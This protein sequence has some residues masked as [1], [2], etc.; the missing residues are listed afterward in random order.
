M[1]KFNI[2]DATIVTPTNVSRGVITVQDGKI[3]A[4]IPEEDFNAHDNNIPQIDANGAYVLPG[5][6]DIHTDAI[7][8]EIM[9]RKGADFPIEIAFRELERRMSGCG[10]TT[11]YHSMH[12]G[13]KKAE[14]SAQ[15][16]YSRKEI[17]DRIH[18]CCNEKSV[19]NNKIHLRFELTGTYHYD[20]VMELIESG[21]ID[22]L[23]VMDH[24]PGQG[25]YGKISIEEW[26]KRVEISTDEAAKQLEELKNQDC[27]DGE[28]LTSMINLAVKKGIAVASHDDDSAE[29]VEQMH[30]IGINISEFPINDEAAQRALEL[31]MHTVAG[32][33]NVIR[34][35]SLSGNLNVKEAIQKNLIQS[36][37]SDYYPPSILHALFM[38]VNDQVLSLPQAANLTALNPAKSVN[39]SDE[40]GSIEVGKN[41]D[42]IVVN[43]ENKLPVVSHTFV[44]GNLA[45]MASLKNHVN[46]KEPCL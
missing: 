44:N 27:I 1:D 43:L 18:A 34:G 45:A 39:I 17:F 22:L 4:I 26:A 40:T 3:A 10:I 32:A 9:P 37:C 25:Q 24:R 2:I 11:V 23:S 20:L 7:D 19:I 8:K 38:L 42:L 13:Y 41:A 12:L 14:E 29:K 21:K 15:S 31:N 33:S 5:I 46:V 30:K 6:I 36:L 16:K 28:R 35:G